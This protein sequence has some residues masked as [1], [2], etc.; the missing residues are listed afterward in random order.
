MCNWSRP[1]QSTPSGTRWNWCR[2]HVR[3]HRTGTQ[4]R[5]AHP[6][7]P[8]LSLGGTGNQREHQRPAASVPAQE[9]RSDPG[10]PRATARHRS[11]PESPAPQVPG[12]CKSLRG[13][14][15][16]A[17]RITLAA[18]S[19]CGYTRSAVVEDR[20]L[21]GNNP[22]AVAARGHGRCC[23]YQASPALHHV[24]GPKRKI[25]GVWGQSPQSLECHLAIGS[26]AIPANACVALRVLMR[27][28]RVHPRRQANNS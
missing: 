15:R 5:S 10:R 27:L 17:A 14:P 1:I 8:S 19:P 28:P 7:R 18:D 9:H 16:P 24:P 6:L 11:R 3:S 2:V 26:L 22:S 20:A 13:L 21:L 23:G 12:L 4:T 25:P